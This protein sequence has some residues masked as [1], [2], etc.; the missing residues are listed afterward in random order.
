MRTETA[1]YQQK[2]TEACGQNSTH[3]LQL[4]MQWRKRS[5]IWHYGLVSAKMVY[6]TPNYVAVKF[7]KLAD[8]VCCGI[9]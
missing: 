8:A 1:L 6:N 9:M 4:L 2:S 7:T 5:G 3:S